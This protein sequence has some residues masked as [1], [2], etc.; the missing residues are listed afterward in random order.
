MKITTFIFIFVSGTSN[1]FAQEINIKVSEVL[2]IGNY[3]DGTEEYL[4]AGPKFICTDSMYNIYVADRGM[5]KIRVF[6]K[7][8]K[9]VKS[10]GRKGQGPGEMREVTCMTL[11][12]NENLI[13]AD[14]MNQ[15]FTRFINMGEET[16][17]YSFVEK[18]WIDPW[19]ICSLDSESYIFYYRKRTDEYIRHEA[20][21]LIHIYDKNFS[22]IITSFANAGEILDFKQPFLKSESGSHY[23]KLSVLNK[24]KIIISPG[25]YDGTLYFYEQKDGDWQLNPVK[26][27]KPERGSYKLLNRNDYPDKKYPMGYMSRSGTSGRFAVQRLNQ[28]TGLFVLNDGV[29]IHFIR[30][31]NK[32]DVY[33]FSIEL[34]SHDGQFLGHTITA[35]EHQNLLQY[36]AVLWK[37]KDDKFYLYAY[38]DGIPF[39]SVVKLDIEIK[40]Q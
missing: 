1:L 6:D 20:D 26:G 2:N 39:I 8:G 3:E 27:K 32:N 17:T 33:N 7:Q 10:I 24:N 19:L 35:R 36:A 38:V 21:K 12:H 23:F 25:F 11:D 15:R 34:F 31:L 13:I 5:V 16:E 37:D 40:K 18:T 29:I 22:R 9:F 28:S 14:R 4:F 30:T